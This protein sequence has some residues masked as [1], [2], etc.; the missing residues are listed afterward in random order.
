MLKHVAIVALVVLTVA[1]MVAVRF[2]TGSTH[3]VTGL[4]IAG[5]L[6]LVSA[7]DSFQAIGDTIWL[8]RVRRNR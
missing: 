3:G 8:W 6:L 4:A 7:A 1:G 2:L 5:G